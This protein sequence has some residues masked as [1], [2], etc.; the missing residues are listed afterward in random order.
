MSAGAAR[1][2]IALSEADTPRDALL[3]M[4]AQYE[5]IVDQLRRDAAQQEALREG[6]AAEGEARV[7]ERICSVE[8]EASARELQRLATIEAIRA[9]AAVQPALA[10]ECAACRERSAAL[11]ELREQRAATEGA[12]RATLAAESERL[13]GARREV[14]ELHAARA[15]EA[16]LASEG[17][18][19]EGGAAEVGAALEAKEALEE[20][21]ALEARLEASE[22]EA[23]SL[24]E[25][26]GLASDAAR[27][28]EAEAG[29]LGRENAALREELAEAR[30]ELGVSREELDGEG[31]RWA[32]ALEEVR[33][34]AARREAELQARSSRDVAEI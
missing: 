15:R 3:A 23:R 31:A 16:L 1:G 19:A 27:R 7:I 22:A 33:S 32:R 17:G 26:C 21:E 12:L 14:L 9:Q 4:Q 29:E 20:R 10:A 5:R 11:R 34:S 30:E 13:R 24:R 25:E 18:A 6:Q 2:E 8:R 28:L